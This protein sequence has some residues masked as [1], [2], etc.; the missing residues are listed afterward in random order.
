VLQVC[1]VKSF[2]CRHGNTNP[3]EY[4]WS[5]YGCRGEGKKDLV[6]DLDTSYLALGNNNSQ[7][8]AAYTEYVLGTVPDYEIKLIRESLQRG[9]LTGSDRF[10]EEIFSRLGIR[11]SNKGPGRLKKT[12]ID[13]SPFAA[14][15]SMRVTV[16]PLLGR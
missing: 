9:Q 2:T 14:I 13:L 15:Q 7:R 3:G 12:K 4:R 1:R 6:V 16:V 5:S 11:F 8:W 10:R